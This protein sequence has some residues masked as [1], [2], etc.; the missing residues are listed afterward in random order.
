MVDEGDHRIQDKTTVASLPYGH[1]ADVGERGLLMV[2][3]NRERAGRRI[4]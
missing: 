4:D 2:L 3:G 1:V